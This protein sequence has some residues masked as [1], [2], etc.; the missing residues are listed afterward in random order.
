MERAQWDLFFAPPDTRVVDRPELLYSSTPRDLPHLNC[1]VR[2]RLN[3][4]NRA[5]AIEEVVAAHK[6]VTS[7]WLVHDWL[8]DGALGPALV[9]TGYR[10]T[11]VH[12][13]YAT[14]PDL[15]LSAPHDLRIRRVDTMVGLL[16]SE[17][18]FSRAFGR[19]Q[20]VTEEH[21]DHRL[22]QCARPTG[23]IHRFVA[24][25]GVGPV[26]SG[27]ITLFPKL[28][29]A[30]LWRGGT[31]P[32]ARGRGAYKAILK[33]R[34]RFAKETGISLVGLY[35]KLETSAPIVDRLGFT[36]QGHMTF[37]DRPPTL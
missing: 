35:A 28:G 32:E 1:V 4:G 24:Y 7:E 8:G 26:S 3:D 27:A 29:F 34:M 23:R 18:V 33:E 10:P 11:V 25:N 30:M 20:H 22:E 9:S 21:A 2:T 17:E 6:G 15:E 16:H 19:Q 14:H 12:R 13:A 31:V 36:G 5:A 37:W